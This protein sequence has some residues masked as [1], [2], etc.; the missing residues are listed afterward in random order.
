[1]PS[2]GEREQESSG[3]GIAS[4]D[5]HQAGNEPVSRVC[6][7][8]EPVVSAYQLKPGE[9]PPAGSEHRI[10]GH[11][12]SADY[13]HRTGQFRADGAG[14]LHDFSLL[15]SC[16]VYYLNAEADLRDVPLE[17]HLQ[18][19]LYQ[20][21]NGDFTTAGLVRDDVTKLGPHGLETSDATTQPTDA[22]RSA[23]EQQ[24]KKHTAF[25]KQR[26][27]PARIDRVDGKKLV[28]TLLGD[29]AG[30]AA[31]FKD[32]GIAPAQWAKEHREVKAVVANE[33][34]RTYNPP[35]DGEQ[36]TIVDF[37][38]LP[39]GDYGTSG[40]QWTIEPRLLLE[41]F[42]RGRIIRLFAPGWPVN[43]MPF[44]ETLYTERPGA[45]ME[46]ESPN[47]YSYR[48]DFGNEQLQWYQLK[49]G[50]FPP[51]QSQH[52][53]AGEL[54]K[55]DAKHRS[56]Q[57]RTDGT[58]AVVDFTLPPFAAIL[59]LNAEAEFDEL[60]LGRRYWFYLYRDERGAFTHAA[61]V[62]DEFTRL[63]NEKSSYR[64][65]S[66]NAAE[67]KIFLADQ[68]DEMK[69]DKD[70]TIRPPDLSHAELLLDDT[71]HVWKD[72]KPA[73][74][75]DIAPGEEL[76]INTTAATSSALSRCTDIWIGLETHKQAAAEQRAKH[77]AFVQQ[78]G[79]PGWIESRKDKQI[80]V[81]FF[82][83]NRRDFQDIKQ[84][85][86]WGQSV[87]VHLCD[88]DLHPIDDHP[89]LLRITG[90]LPEQTTFGTYG[91]SGARWVLESDHLP[92]DFQPGR[93]VRVVKPE[94][95]GHGEGK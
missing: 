44:G 78:H 51:W 24:R 8:P 23:T 14:E 88:N 49:P 7:A 60:P 86:P 12:V 76:L 41:G 6:A 27:L 36:S 34:L 13:I 81:S 92:E 69:D 2:T 68:L 15:A 40:V 1:P 85:E 16:P 4:L 55:I 54:L 66:V 21:A 18:F 37:H 52:T 22:E 17:T 25:L 56:G 48:T 29:P 9:F 74:I 5:T 30:L 31:L 50:I 26:G 82:A 38:E 33:E 65:E 47:Q 28:I 35:V 75:S 45:K 62:M 39:T 73:K 11:L 89:Q 10:S 63:S 93:V 42:R 71:A 57:F 77:K 80:T 64:V 67:G 70:H 87:T 91:S 3:S 90:N 72:N 19:Y 43:D 32:Q 46:E 61:V 53:V 59:Y 84:G 95:V 94:W 58:G 20:D 79:M 83:G